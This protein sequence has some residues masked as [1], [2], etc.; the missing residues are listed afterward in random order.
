[1]AVAG[2]LM[3]KVRGE[4]EAI[5]YPMEH[6]HS[7][8][9]HT[10]KRDKGWCVMWGQRHEPTILSLKKKKGGAQRLAQKHVRP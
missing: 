9:Q 7:T 1:M 5:Y 10:A 3:K 8:A 6:T 4:Q 2:E